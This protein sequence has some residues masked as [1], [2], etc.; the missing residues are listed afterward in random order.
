MRA[1]NTPGTGRKKSKLGCLP[2]ILIALVVVGINV[3][4]AVYHRFAVPSGVGAAVRD[5]Y[6]N[7]EL[8]R[9]QDARDDICLSYR[10]VWDTAQR[11]PRSDIN[12][13]IGSETVSK[14]RKSGSGWKVPV[15]VR[16]KTGRTESKSLKVIKEF[17]DYEICGGLVP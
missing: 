17:G 2:I 7:M 15:T 12:A 13:D 8:N 10:P 6:L 1:A 16:L 3:G 5:Y 9:P 11:D 4:Q 14:G